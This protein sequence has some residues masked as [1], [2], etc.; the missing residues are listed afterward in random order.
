MYD[1]STAS[2]FLCSRVVSTTLEFSRVQSAYAFRNDFLGGDH[3]TLVGGEEER[4]REG[5]EE[6][7]RGEGGEEG[8]R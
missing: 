2:Y 5:G 4:G 3:C 7:G 8:G 1:C 6:G